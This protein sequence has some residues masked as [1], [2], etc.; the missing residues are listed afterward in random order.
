MDY[1]L[2]ATGFECIAKIIKHRTSYTLNNTRYEIDDYGTIPVFIE[3][4][5]PSEEALIKAAE[6]L[7][8]KKE[9]LFL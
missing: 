3:F 6:A 5:S 9:D 1:I 8:F 4:E 7:G 2:K